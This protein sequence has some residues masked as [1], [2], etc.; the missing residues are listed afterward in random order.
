MMLQQWPENVSICIPSYKAALTLDRFLSELLTRVP[1]EKIIVIDDAS[2]DAT[3]QVC[4]K[5]GVTCL[6]HT[7][8]KGKGA[9]LRTGFT[10][11]LKQGNAAWAFTMDA[12]GQHAIADIDHFLLY[13][14]QHPSTAI[15]V[16]YREMQIGRMPILRILSNRITSGIMSIY[17]R[18]RICDSQCGYRIYSLSFISSIT[19]EYNRFEMESEVLLKAATKGLDI[20]FI[21]IQ[22]LYLDG[23][24]HI[25][26]FYDTIR[27]VRAV[28][29]VRSRLK[30]VQK[31]KRAPKHP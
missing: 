15:C 21:P 17:C 12:D 11:L 13:I 28:T 24:S 20:G 2:K 6:T 7:V 26:H 18:Q 4:Q 29:T 25:S 1:A 16:G 14:N 22:T 5:H 23:T 8:N 9:A 3:N 10:H 27:W 19:I 31:K 30:Q